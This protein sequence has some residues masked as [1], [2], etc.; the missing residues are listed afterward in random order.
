[1]STI[2]MQQEQFQA[3]FASYGILDRAY[4]KPVTREGRTSFA[5]H[6]ADGTY[7]FCF[8]SRELA[9]AALRQQEMEPLSVH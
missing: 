2:E 1:M 5:V 9:F 7:L 6:A 4:V 8:V 3:E